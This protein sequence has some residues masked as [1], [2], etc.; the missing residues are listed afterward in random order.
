[1]LLRKNLYVRNVYVTGTAN[2]VKSGSTATTG[3]GIW[4]QIVEYCYNNTHDVPSVPP[5]TGYAKVTL[6]LES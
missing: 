5:N 3:T 6:T 2:L 4:K 1:M